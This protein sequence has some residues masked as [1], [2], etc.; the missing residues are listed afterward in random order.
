MS[1]VS[2]F[3]VSVAAVFVLGAVGEI[4]FRRTNIPDVIWLIAAGVV[5]GPVLGLVTREQLADAAPFFAAITLVV[6]LFEGG[7]Q[8]RIAELA[9]AA[10]RALGLS[11]AT[12]SVTVAVLAAVSVGLARA[13]LL[14]EEWSWMHGAMLGCI[15]GGSS[16]IIVM[17]SVAQA[18]IESRLANLVGLESALTD[19]FCVVGTAALVDLLAGRGTGAHPAETLGKSFGIGLGLGLASGFFWL[20]LL[21]RLRDSTH[22]YPLTL[23]FLMLVYVGADRAGGSAAFCILTTAIVVGNARSIAPK[24]GLDHKYVLTEGVQGFHSQVTFIVK[25]FFFT[26]IGAMLG[27][28]WSF[29]ALGAM[30]GLVLVAA[31]VPGVYAATIGSGLDGP[32]KAL[33]LVSMPR[34]MAAGVLSTLPVTAGVPGTENLPVLVFSCVVTSILVFAGGFPLVRKRMA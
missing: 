31:R 28:P 23:S 26:F 12:F 20:L 8:L 18:R 29:L 16:S 34:G 24:L 32:R 17:P 7:S 5:I 22:A 21:R 14:P 9:S 13:G 1:P 30:L 4:V 3:L 27:P 19:A 25:S 2:V 33:V 11:L 15:L 10:P 6:V